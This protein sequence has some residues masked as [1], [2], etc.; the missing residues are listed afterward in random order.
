MNALEIVQ[1]AC[2]RVGFAVPNTAA[3]STDPQVTQ[4]LSLLNEEGRDL[5]S[6][7][8]WTNLQTEATFTSVATVSQGAL[9][10][11]APGFRRFISETM[12]N[13]SQQ[14]EAPGPITPRQYQRLKSGLAS[15]IDPAW[16]VRG[17]NLM[18]QPAPAAGQSYSFEYIDKRWAVAADATRKE[19][20][21]RDD[22]THL[23]DDDALLLG[24][25]WR[26]RQVKG[27]EYAEDF[28]KA[29]RKVSSLMGEDGSAPD[30]FL[31]GGT[32]MDDFGVPTIPDGNWTV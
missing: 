27:L 21:T 6:R 17:G 22:D 4:M 13:R 31:H 9:S 29:E 30:M 20:F 12:W 15:L 26:W 1:E 8:D 11:L 14:R 28:T 2:R 25:I 19:Q 18:L 32:F 10:T 5:S 23:L 7:F 3:N 24:L 16:Y